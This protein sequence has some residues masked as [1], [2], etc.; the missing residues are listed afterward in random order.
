MPHTAGV[1]ESAPFVAEIDVRRPII[2][3]NGW[4]LCYTFG[5]RQVS[6]QQTEASPLTMASPSRGGALAFSDLSRALCLAGRNG[7]DGG[8][9]MLELA[10]A[11]GE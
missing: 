10:K 5:G 2:V 6:Y 9:R 1:R 8:P 3:A 11:L 4:R 7:S